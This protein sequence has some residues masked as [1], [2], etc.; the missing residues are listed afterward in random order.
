M[1]LVNSLLVRLG[2]QQSACF[3]DFSDS[4]ALTCGSFWP[5]KGHAQVK[6]MSWWRAARQRSWRR[7]PASSTTG[8]GSGMCWSSVPG[9][10][11]LPSAGEGVAG[12]PG[13]GC[14]IFTRQGEV[15]S[16]GCDSTH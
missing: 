14:R 16:V 13:H 7:R 12:V 10:G 9:G 15:V 5:L 3:K 11:V 1:E 8:S 6:W 4:V 2:S